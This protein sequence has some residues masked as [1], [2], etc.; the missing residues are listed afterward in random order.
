MGSGKLAKSGGARLA[1][2]GSLAPGK[3]NEHIL[4][5]IGGT[6]RTGVVRGR[7]VSEGWGA[8]LG[9][10]ALVLDPQGAP[11]EVQLLEAD[12]L[13]SHWDRLDAFE[14]DG[15][16]RVVTDVAVGQETIPAFIYV[17]ASNT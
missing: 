16:S 10:P 15:Y 1:V 6:W 9:F 2:Y 12:E 3:P 17:L 14:G 8:D 13:V 4:A 7:L 5:A 11:V